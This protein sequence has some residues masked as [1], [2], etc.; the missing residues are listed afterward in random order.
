MIDPVQIVRGR[1]REI[2]PGVWYVPALMANLFF[3]GDRNEPWVMVDA[4]LP[5]CAE[6]IR[7]A[8]EEI[9][10]GRRPAAIVLT[11]GHFDHVGALEELASAWDVP[12]YAHT[13]EQPYLNGRDNYPPPDPTVG[14]FMA[15]L[16]RVFPARGINVGNRLRTLEPGDSFELLPGWQILHTPG[17]SPG[18]VSLFRD[19]D[20]TLLAGDAVITIDQQNP[21]KLVMRGRE[22]FP[23]PRY[24]TIDWERAR[25]SVRKL[26]ELQ[27]AT[28][29]T[30][31][32]LPITGEAAARML[33]SLSE[34]FAS[35]APKHG[36]YVEEPALADDQ[37]VYYVPPKP[38]DPAI[39]YAAGV[40]IA[41]AGF[42][43]FAMREG[44]RPR[45]AGSGRSG[46]KPGQ[47]SEAKT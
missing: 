38:R 13:L 18:H 11:H 8:A 35:R 15:Q 14:G 24:F 26:A 7:A 5:G 10:G 22:V 27:P 1:V 42:M 19:S 29:A 9:Y 2:A 32:G 25:Q 3:A 45:P 4:G 39:L 21:V 40:A 16:S 34:S 6:W 36:R 33:T 46:L 43:A 47:H 23:P 30:G 37:G 44:R 12:V 28:L 17:H 31:H 20:R 41:A